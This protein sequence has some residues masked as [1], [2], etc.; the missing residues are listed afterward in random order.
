MVQPIRPQ[1][2]TGIYQ[3]QVAGAEQASA[4]RRSEAAGGGGASRRTDQVQLSSDARSFARIM[5]A[6]SEQPE[7]RAD[8]VEELRARV[9]S[10]SY[11]VDADA[12]AQLL[13]SRG[14]G[15]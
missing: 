14:L 13:L 9:E 3:R 7:V 6:V 15:S 5:Q 8:R 4:L 11:R 2:A 1:D 12:L 10:G